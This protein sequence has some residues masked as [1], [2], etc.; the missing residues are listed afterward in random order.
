MIV[1][2]DTKTPVT[3]SELGAILQEA[4]LPDGVSTRDIDQAFRLVRGLRAGS[5]WVNGRGWLMP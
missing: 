1:K 5:V 2:P 4:G 3:A